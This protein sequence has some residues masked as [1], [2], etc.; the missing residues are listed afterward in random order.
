MLNNYYRFS[1]NRSFL[2]ERLSFH[3]NFHN[4]DKD[5]AYCLNLQLSN[6]QMVF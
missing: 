2:R 1:E 3:I 5:Y 6:F 4:N